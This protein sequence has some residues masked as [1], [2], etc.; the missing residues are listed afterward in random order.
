MAVIKDTGKV[1]IKGSVGTIH[2]VRID[3]KIFATGKK[4]GQNIQDGTHRN[5]IQKGNSEEILPDDKN[6]GLELGKKVPPT[7]V[8]F[9]LRFPRGT[10]Q[11]SRDQTE[12]PISTGNKAKERKQ[13]DTH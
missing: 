11:N 8:Q 10:C 2:A 6:Q 12:R 4:E 5:Q 9:V 1:W 13:Q 7:G 3:D